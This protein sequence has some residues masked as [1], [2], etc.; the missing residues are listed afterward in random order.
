MPVRLWKCTAF[1]GQVE[2]CEDIRK[3]ILKGKEEGQLEDQEHISRRYF[4]AGTPS[5]LICVLCC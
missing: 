1:T 5:T 3:L 2:Q 4:G